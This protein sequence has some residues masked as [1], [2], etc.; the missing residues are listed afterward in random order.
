MWIVPKL[1]NADKLLTDIAAGLKAIERQHPR[2]LD[3]NSIE[4]KLLQ[5]LVLNCEQ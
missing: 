1:K 3:Y 2:K 5:Q 4:V